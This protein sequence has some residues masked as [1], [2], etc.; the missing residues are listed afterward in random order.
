[1]NPSGSSPSYA[2]PGSRHCQFG[3]SSRSESQRSVRHELATS[4]PL[5]DHMVDRAVGEAA[6][7][8]EAGLPASDDY[9]RC[10]HRAR[11]CPAA[12]LRS[13]DLDAHV[14]RVRDDVVHRGPLLRLRNERLDLVGRRIGVDVV[15]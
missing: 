9:R 15:A 3:V 4:P 12:T 14:G 11:P 1:M 8:R 7:H 13:D 6:T 2:K 5:E 10:A